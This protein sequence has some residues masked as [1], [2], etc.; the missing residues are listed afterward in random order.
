MGAKVDTL[1]KRYGKCDKF[2]TM[3][4]EAKIFNISLGKCGKLGHKSGKKLIT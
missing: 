3:G 4:G 1:G 2:G